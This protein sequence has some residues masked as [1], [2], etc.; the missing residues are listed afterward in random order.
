VR[1]DKGGEVIDLWGTP[2]IDECTRFVIAQ[3]VTN[4]APDTQASVAVLAAAIQGYQADNGMWIGGMPER[5][6]SDN[7]PE[8][9]TSAA[10]GT[11]AQCDRGDRPAARRAGTGPEPESAVQ[12][13]R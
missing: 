9:K 12:V 8:Y 1:D 2:V 3:N 13:G 11:P 10:A 4:G 6:L 5:V 7:G